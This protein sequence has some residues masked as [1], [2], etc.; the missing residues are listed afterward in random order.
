MKDGITQAL[1]N[2]P[3][4]LYDPSE[5]HD[6]CGVGFVASHCDAFEFL[7]FAKEILDQMPPFIHLLVDFEGLGTARM[8]RDDDLGT[9]FVEGCDDGVAVERLVPK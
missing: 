2:A 6:S 5:E 1:R 4:S 9:A 8:L 7:Q 3:A